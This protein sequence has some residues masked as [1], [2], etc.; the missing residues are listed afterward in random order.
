MYQV[1]SSRGQSGGFSGQ[2][3]GSS[4]Q[5]GGSVVSQEVLLLVRRF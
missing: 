3:G 2:S 5:S 4:G 1:K